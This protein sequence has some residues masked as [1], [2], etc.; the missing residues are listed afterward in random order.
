MLVQTV[1]HPFQV[2]HYRF[3]E[4]MPQLLQRLKS[5]GYDLHAM[6]NYPIW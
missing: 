3:I 5:A 4:G 6:S 2:E 1:P